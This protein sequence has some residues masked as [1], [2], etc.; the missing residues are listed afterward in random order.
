MATLWQEVKNLRSKSQEHWVDALEQ[1]PRT[2]DS[3]QNEVNMQHDSAT[4]AAQTVIPQVGAARRYKTKNCN[5]LK[6]KRLPKKVTFTQAYKKKRGPDHGLERWTRGQDFQRRN[7]NK[8]NVG[9]R[10]NSPIT[11]QKFFARPNFAHG[12]KH[13]NDGRS[14]DQR[15][16][17]S[18][19]RSDGNWSRNESFN[20]QNGIWR[21]SR[22]ETIQRRDL[23]RNSSY[24]QLRSDQPNNSAFRRSDDRPTTGFTPYEQKFPETICRLH[25]MWFASPPP[26]IPIMKCQIPVH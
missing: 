19:N 10:R 6:T 21:N 14:Y 13:L 22:S 7:Q 18:F 17:Q 9:F 23:S 5:E 3:N 12:S 26:M 11:H 8:T 20:N 1:K 25:L 4:T 24:R 15:P 2:V 16:N